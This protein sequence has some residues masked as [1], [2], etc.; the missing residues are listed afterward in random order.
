MK[1]TTITWITFI[2]SAMILYLIE[3]GSI[4]YGYKGYWVRVGFAVLWFTSLIITCIAFTHYK[5]AKGW[6]WNK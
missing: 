5:E 4:I 2:V 6:P 3:G 1:E